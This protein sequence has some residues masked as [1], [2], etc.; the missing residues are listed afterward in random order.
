MAPS[1]SGEAHSRP[2]TH[3]DAPSAAE[4]FT[5]GNGIPFRA[6]EIC[7]GSAALAIGSGFLS[8]P[9]VYR[10]FRCKSHLISSAVPPFQ[11]NAQ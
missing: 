2:V 8:V 4:C 7:A 1:E 11:S 10:L 6:N 9:S 5:G 3:V